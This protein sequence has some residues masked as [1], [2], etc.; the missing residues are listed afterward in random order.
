MHEET[1]VPTS[2]QRVQTRQRHNIPAQPTALI[3]RA[4]EVAMARQLLQHADVRL[5]TITGPGGVGKTR[6]AIQVA[7]DLLDEYTDGVYFV[8]LAPMSDP[9]L[10]VPTIAQTL[11]LRE[12]GN[13]SFYD[14]LQEYL[15]DKQ[16]LLLLDNFEQVVKAAP[17]LAELLLSCPNLKALVTSRAALHVRA[18]YE[19]PVAPLLRPDVKRLPALEALSQ[20]AA[21]VLFVQRARAV[22]PDF[23]LTEA[24]APAVAEICARLDGLPLAIELAAARLKLLPPQALL[25][26]LVGTGGHKLLAGGPQDAPRRQ[27]TLRNTIDWSYHLLSEDEQKLFRWLCLFVGGCTLEA[28]E[29]VCHAMSALTV[30]VL[31]GV[32]SILD[33]NLLRQ[34]E[35]MSGEPRLVLLETIREYGL[36]CLR[37]GGEL[38]A[39]QD[40]HAA[41]YLALA[42][43][44]EPKLT[45]SEQSLWLERLET[46]HDNL[47][48]ALRWS[49]ERAKDGEIEP[50]LRLGGALWRF[51]FMKG[52]LSEG[53]RWL[54]EMLAATDGVFTSG[55]AK[56]LGGAGTLA[57]YQGDYPAVGGFC[58]E[59]LA[60]CRRL[61][62]KH[63]MV[64]ALGG[65]AQVAAVRGNYTVARSMDEEGLAIMRELG[66][67]WGTA[68]SLWHLGNVVWMSGDHME[69][70]PLF[71]EALLLFR[72][73]GDTHGSAFVL[74]NLGYV[75]IN[76][77]DY[78]EAGT[79]IEESLTIMKLLGEKRGITR[80]LIGLGH[81]AFGQGNYPAAHMLYWEAS[82]L[83]KELGDTWFFVQGLEGLAWTAA[84]QGH[85]EQAARLFGAAEILRETLQ[86]P[87]LPVYRSLHEHAQAATRAGLDGARLA[88]AWAA[89]RAMTPAQVLALQQPAPQGEA[90]IAMPVPTSPVGQYPDELTA[91]EVEVLRLVAQG[92]SDAQVAEHLVI[93]PHTVHR[94]LSSIYS[95]IAVSSR[96]AATRYAIDHHLA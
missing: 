50:A 58:E 65:L 38:V 67:R 55:R 74:C 52:Y 87:V 20:Y 42:Q 56:A 13:R 77:G 34:V 68:N 73:L 37:E 46:E 11:G 89:G 64:G 71:Q 16:L 12:V 54:E 25:A 43:E 31:D 92:L 28:A 72:E 32:T 49:I 94:H 7:A 57:F 66:D 63:G 48:A 96:S 88:A 3:G 76:R 33:K 90:T 53:R 93:S 80:C 70:Q 26:R 95:K 86:I 17:R 40:A 9:Q 14:L 79:L 21:I 5:L 30:D 1:L 36:A 6:L 41:Y 75:A 44:A 15:L 2:R 39:T 61:G 85:Y 51:W 47:R 8:S 81:C 82:E 78:R 23:E 45:T 69:T 83:L 18:E 62:D 10:V 29:A 59:N 19:F 35:Q 60:L 24:N 4:R 22:K 91:R 84:A 27:Q